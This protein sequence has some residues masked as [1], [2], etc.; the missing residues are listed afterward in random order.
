MYRWSFKFDSKKQICL[1]L[2]EEW[3]SFPITP[4]LSWQVIFQ[5]YRVDRCLGITSNLLLFLLI[6][7]LPDRLSDQYFLPW[8]V[9][10]IGPFL[11][12]FTA[13][14]SLCLISSRPVCHYGFLTHFSNLIFHFIHFIHSH[15]KTF[16]EHC[17]DHHYSLPSPHR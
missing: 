14:P 6:L 15:H 1:L 11:Y 2:L 16:P 4:F 5:L 10:Q 9:P 13:Y 3:F 17:F 8:N 7:F 12:N